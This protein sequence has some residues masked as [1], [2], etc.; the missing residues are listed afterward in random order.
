[1][2]NLKKGYSVKEIKIQLLIHQ[3]QQQQQF[4]QNSS[5][6]IILKP[7]QLCKF[8]IQKANEPIDSSSTLHQIFLVA[9][10]HLCI[11]KRAT[12]CYLHCHYP[13]LP[14]SCLKNPL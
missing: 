14:S 8:S 11:E 10:F 3:Q 13:L 5:L 6:C 2:H 7:I 4:K 9:K 1:M 12:E